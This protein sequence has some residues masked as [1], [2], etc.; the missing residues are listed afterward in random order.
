MTSSHEFIVNPVRP[1]WIRPAR[2]KNTPVRRS[3]PSTESQP[4][5]TSEFASDYISFAP[6]ST[7]FNLITSFSPVMS[8]LSQREYSGRRTSSS[9]SLLDPAG[10]AAAAADGQKLFRPLEELMAIFGDSDLDVVGLFPSVWVS[11][12]YHGSTR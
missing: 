1:P 6:A 7:P 3:T 10:A 9:R 4:Q 5:D 8:A 12:I 2:K 11:R